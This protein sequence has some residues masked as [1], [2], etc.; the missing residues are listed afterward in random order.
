MNHKVLRKHSKML[1]LMCAGI[2]LV[3]I[4]YV[5]TKFVFDSGNTAGKLVLTSTIFAV[6]AFIFGILTI[7]RWQGFI[8]LAAFSYVMYS[9]LLA[10][11]L[12]AV[13]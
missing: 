6:L 4:I 1:S 11:S 8:A 5:Q 9:I 13:Q 7:P 2:S 3:L 12:Y 10:S